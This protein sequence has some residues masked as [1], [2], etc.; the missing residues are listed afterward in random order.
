M[1]T[2]MGKC[3]RCGKYVATLWDGS[4]TYYKA[5][6]NKEGKPCR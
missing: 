2:T 5:H 6:K 3:P 4:K 1:A